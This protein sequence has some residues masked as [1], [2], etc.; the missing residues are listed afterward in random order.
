MCRFGEFL[1]RL[2]IEITFSLGSVQNQ[3][4]I[5][6]LCAEKMPFLGFVQK[7]YCPLRSRYQG[8]IWIPV[9]GHFWVCEEILVFRRNIHLCRVAQLTNFNFNLC[10][11]IKSY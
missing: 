10:L 8:G 5:L 9:Q 11:R 6:L 1:I 3:I 2:R 7:N 4:D